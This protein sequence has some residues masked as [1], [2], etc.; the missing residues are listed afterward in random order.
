MQEGKGFIVIFEGNI[1]CNTIV[2]GE[3]LGK[4]EK[5]TGR[6]F[7]GKSGE[8]IRLNIKSIE[9]HVGFMNTIF[10][11]PILNKTPTNNQILQ[12]IDIAES[13]LD[14]VK[15]KNAIAVG[16]IAKKFIEMSK[17][18]FQGKI[19]NIYHP[20]FYLRNRK[21]HVLD[22][23]E[24]GIKSMI[25]CSYSEKIIYCIIRKIC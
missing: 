2:I 3:A 14:I 24:K 6:I 7:I 21:S 15:P 19:C 1:M 17:Y 20:S 8:I 23:I 5:E 10:Y 16:S 12:H 25:D 4:S 11:K 13:I 22:N 9:P 18:K